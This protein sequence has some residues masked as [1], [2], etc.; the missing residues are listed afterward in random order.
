MT[1]KILINAVDPEECRIATVKDGRLEDFTIET[2]AR[3]ITR[4]NIYKG[5]VVRVEPSL[6]AVFVDYGAG[7]H[8]FLQRH[9]IHQ[10]Y[11]QDNIATD[12]NKKLSIQQV[13]KSGQELLIQVTKDETGNKG[14][15]LTTFISLAGRYL[16]L[17]PGSTNRGISRKIEDEKERQ[18]L[19]KVIESLKISKEFGAIVRTVGEGQTKTALSSDLQYLLR[20]WRTINELGISQP[21]PALLYKERHVVI[22]SLR[23]RFTADVKEI[24]VDNSDVFQDVKQFMKI[25]APRQA[26]V[27][28]LH[29]DPKPV[30]TK[31]NLENQIA[32]IFARR[33][34]LKSGGSIIIDPTEALVAIDVNSGKATKEKSIEST[35]FKTNIEAV[36]EITRQLRLRDLGGLIVIDFIDMRDKKHKMAVEKELKSGTK[37]DKAR[38]SIGRISKFGLMEMSRQ[39]LRPSIEYGT[40]I[41][42]IYCRGKGMTPSVE[43]LALAFLRKLRSAAIKV[44]NGRVKGSVPIDVAD[45]LLNKKRKELL[46][47]EQRHNLLILIE[48]DRALPP[49]EDRIVCEKE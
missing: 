34:P 28:K 7:R 3:E 45:Y 5:V 14:A 15:M 18:R 40:Y 41:P 39:R 2:S 49:G 10:D 6:Q 33:V 27:V 36:E 37:E 12:K 25:I 43:T 16:V 11:Y 9:E 48:G 32:S 21:A 13:I 29:N 42:C 19:K 46:A 26:R 44:E 38:I 24:L 8:G 31:Y 23:D 1:K 20:L 4:G 30:F 22:R 47:I 17:M 35:A